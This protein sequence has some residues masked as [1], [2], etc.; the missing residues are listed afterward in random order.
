VEE[1]RQR[2]LTGG[3]IEYTDRL[4]NHDQSI[5]T[6]CERRKV[7]RAAEIDLQRKELK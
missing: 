7:G 2:D 5:L 6:G 3:K 1:R 4:A